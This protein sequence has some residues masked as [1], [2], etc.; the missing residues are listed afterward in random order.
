M[1]L[2]IVGKPNVGKST[3]FKAAT[4]VDVDIANYPF[5][6]IK[7]NVG[8]SYVR[9]KCPHNEVNA[10]CSPKNAKCINGIRYVPIK[11]IDVAGLVPGAHENIG[12]GNQFLDDLRQADALIHVVDAAGTT[13]LKGETT[14]NHDP[15]EDIEFLEFEIVMW[16][17]NIL[18]KSWTRFARKVQY[19]NLK[20]TRV[21]AEQFTGLGV[22]EDNVLAA[23]KRANVDDKKPLE[24]SE[25]EIMSFCK[26]LR[27]I[28]KPIVIAAN[29]V[30]LPGAQEN[31]KRIKE[32]YP[33]LIVVPMSADFEL[34]LRGAD[35]NKII[36]YAPGESDFELLNPD[37]LNDQQ[38]NALEHIKE[39]VLKVNGSTGVQTVIDKVVFELL[40][41]MVVFPV[42]D[43]KKW[44][45]K[46]GNVLPD[47]FLVESGVTSRQ[48][49]Y[50][51]HSDI[52][53]NFVCAIDGRS[54]RR[55]SEDH[56]VED[57]DIISIM[58]NKR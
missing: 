25:E 3:F 31:I 34:A 36:K 24:W 56:V 53:D 9:A 10:D 42:E 48:L 30:D 14:E 2:G 5:T 29:K 40:K 12:M 51:I 20:F 15:C 46:N 1:E 43:E 19:E 28:S 38:K 17:A 47:A 18:K 22:T 57:G 32:K 41:M 50:K 37:A 52:G 55:L 58:A 4:L 27:H 33:D 7:K 23:V 16:F 44:T 35:K 54:K 13:N 8:V 21:V 26:S 6:T 11:M 49:A 45:D 39:S